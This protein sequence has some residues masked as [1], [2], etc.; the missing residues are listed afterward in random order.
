MKRKILTRDIVGVLGAH[1]TPTA[2]VHW[3][4]SSAESHSLAAHAATEAPPTT[5][6]PVRRRARW[7]CERGF[8]FHAALQNIHILTS[9]EGASSSTKVSA[10][11]I[12]HSAA[13][14]EAKKI[15]FYRRGITGLA[16]G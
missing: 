12:V 2:A 6:S 9:A 7:T 11:K 16:R 1:G 14:T 3:V 15:L 10:P 13:T 4:S 8:S 5:H